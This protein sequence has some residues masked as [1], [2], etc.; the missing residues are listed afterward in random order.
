[1]YTVTIGSGETF[2]VGAVDISDATATLALDGNASL[3]DG[4]NYSNS[5]A[6]DLDTNY[7]DGGGAL[8]VTGTLANTGAV[9]VGSGYDNLS[10]ATTLSLGALT[11]GTTDSFA[12]YGSSSHLAKMTVTG[13][14]SNAGTIG[15][16]DATATFAGAISGA[17]AYQINSGAVLDLSHGGT[18]AGS[19]GG[20]GT[21]EILGTKTVTLAAGAA[22]SLGTVVQG[23]TVALGKAVAIANAA[24]HTWDMSGSSGSTELLSGGAGSLFTNSGTLEATG[25]GTGTVSSAF[26]NLADVQ[27]SAGKMKFLG[28]TT[29][30]GTM[31]ATA[32]TLKI[33]DSLS[34][35][36]TLNI[37]SAGTITLNDGASAGTALD[38]LTASGLLNL[39]NPI[40]FIGT[41]AGF[42]LGNTIDLK[43]TPETGYSFISGVLTVNNG[44]HTVAALNFAGSYTTSSFKLSSDGAGGTFIKHT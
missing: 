18:V 22:L 31:T 19:I 34:G 37:G 42:V 21:L 30:D 23:G 16:T 44:T 28:P 33:L 1:T 4:G 24:G 27:V 8:T 6:L 7:G 39:Q 26:V 3:N 15:L 5:G 35:T 25:G 9:Q 20:S 38:F 10:A 40:D 29:N 11:N 13:K 41:I 2:T 14:V 43:L 36:G 17:G 32:S 12:M